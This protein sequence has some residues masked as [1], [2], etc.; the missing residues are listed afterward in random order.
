MSELIKTGAR[1]VVTWREILDEVENSVGMSIGG[2]EFVSP[3]DVVAAF[4]ISIR[5]THANDDII[6]HP[7]ILDNDEGGK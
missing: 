5:A 2:W 1:G 7:V 3:F 4:A 6:L